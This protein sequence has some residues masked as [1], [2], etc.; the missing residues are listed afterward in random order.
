MTAAR[1]MQ[2][3]KSDREGINPGA[4]GLGLGGLAKA[5]GGREG[6]TF[7]LRQVAGKMRPV[8]FGW[9]EVRPAG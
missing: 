5:A 9:T 1:G 8:G 7:A 6:K 4:F 2:S 3:G